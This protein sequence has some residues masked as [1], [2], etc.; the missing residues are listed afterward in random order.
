MLRREI[1]NYVTIVILHSCSCQS[2]Q[3]VDSEE[4]YKLPK[5]FNLQRCFLTYSWSTNH[6]QHSW[7]HKKSELNGNITPDLFVSVKN[8]LGAG[9]RC[10]FCENTHTQQVSWGYFSPLK[11]VECIWWYCSWD[12]VLS[13]KEKAYYSNKNR[14][15]P[16]VNIMFNAQ[17]YC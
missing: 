1:I 7:I 14:K 11:N 8:S 15:K 9:G 10:D 16:D 5:I 17:L 13:I 4:C 2:Q 3:S 6:Y 12:Q